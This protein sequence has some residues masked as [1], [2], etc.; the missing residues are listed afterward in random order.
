MESKKTQLKITIIFLLFIAFVFHLFAF[1]L[2]HNLPEGNG[3]K[4]FKRI[5]KGMTLSEIESILGEGVK[6]PP[7]RLPTHPD[8]EKGGEKPV[9]KGDIFYLWDKGEY[10]VTIG[11]VEGK[12]FEKYLWEPSL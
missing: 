9:V 11:F 2:Y 12:V 6:I 1:C 4:I 8:Y 7:E 3:E 5:Q 10:R